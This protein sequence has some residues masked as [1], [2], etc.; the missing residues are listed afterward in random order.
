MYCRPSHRQRAYESRKLAEQ[1]RL[2]TDE[3]LIS[4]SSFEGMRD[5]IYRI[6]AALQD[7]DADLAS[8]ADPDEYRKALWHLYEAAADTRTFTFEPKAVAT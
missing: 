2:G 1:H 4:R 3:V 6:E 7:V 8:G 5:L